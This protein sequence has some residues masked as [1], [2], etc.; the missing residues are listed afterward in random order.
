MSDYIPDPKVDS[1]VSGVILS[2]HKGKPVQVATA[3]ARR[4]WF[5]GGKTPCHRHELLLPPDAN[6]LLLDVE[7]ARK[8]FED[9][10]IPDQRELLIVFTMQF[11][12]GGAMHD[13]WETARSFAREHMVVGHQLAVVLAQHQPGLSGWTAN[14][15]HVH[16]LAFARRLE[17]AHFLG[18]TPLTKAEN[19]ARLAA[20]W[21]PWRDHRI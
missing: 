3:L 10:L 17:A 11:E 7:A 9:Q 5:H 20:L 6:D 14:R 4:L 1:V 19:R 13:Q 2:T 12:P 21:R 16:A 18:F 8:R 15:P